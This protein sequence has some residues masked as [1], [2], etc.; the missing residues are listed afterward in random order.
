MPKFDYRR[1]QNTAARLIGN[2]GQS[3]AIQQPGVVPDEERYNLDYQA[4]PVVTPCSLVVMEYSAFERQSTLIRDD[5]RKVLVSAK[6]LKITPTTADQVIIGGE[7]FEVYD[8]KPF[9]PA[10]ITT[11]Y[12][13]SAGR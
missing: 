11:H 7:A 12:E 5:A 4:I 6:G 1:A 9:S 13:I 2:F 10:G 3:G 8:V